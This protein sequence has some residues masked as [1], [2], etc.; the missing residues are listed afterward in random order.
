MPES[1][2]MPVEPSGIFMG[3]IMGFADYH[4]DL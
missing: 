2:K 3:V 4:S 1:Y